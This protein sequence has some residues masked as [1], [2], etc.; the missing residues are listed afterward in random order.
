MQALAE[1]DIREK[2]GEPANARLVWRIKDACMALSVSRSHVYDLAAAGKLKLVK[3]G[4]RT[5]I[6]DAEVQRL[7]NEGAA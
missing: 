2:N 7:A 5:L 3:I 6:P 1:R 4:G